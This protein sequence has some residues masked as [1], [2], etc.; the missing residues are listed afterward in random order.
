[1]FLA[2]PFIK[3]HGL[4]N[5]FVMIRLDDTKNTNLSKLAKQ[6]SHRNLGIGCDQVIIYNYKA[7]EIEMQILNSDGS[8]AGACG[9]A[10]RCMANINFYENNNNSIVVK[11]GKRSLNCIVH[12]PEKSIAV[13]MGAPSFNENWMPETAVLKELIEP[14]NIGLIDLMCVDIGNP[15][16]ILFVENISLNDM[17]LLGA[18]LEKASLFPEGVNINFAMINENNIMLKVWERNT[19]FTYAC[20]SG[21]CSTFAALNKLGYIANEAIVKFELGNLSMKL[22]EDGNVEMTGPAFKV[23]EGVFYYDE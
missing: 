4:G 11:V 7:E 17:E 14:Y 23:V 9:N 16:I 15:H 21:A 18:K 8:F 13:N 6:A 22:L 20:G 2:I 5:D 3:M 12:N 1:M 10:T 19:G